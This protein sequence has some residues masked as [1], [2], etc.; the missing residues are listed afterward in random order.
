MLD[1]A[2]TH[3]VEDL[4]ASRDGRW[5]AAMDDKHHI[6]VY[7]FKNRELEYSI[8]LRTRLT[9]VS[10]SADSRFLLINHT[11]GLVE[12]FDLADREAVQNYTGHVGGEFMIR[13]AFGGANESFVI[14]GSE[15][16]ATQSTA[17]VTFL[18]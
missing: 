15:G 10:I 3:R 6:H 2:P 18:N 4:T 12:L 16:R 1:W 7:N 5:L 9:S 8:D 13:S 11:N 14:S 17:Q